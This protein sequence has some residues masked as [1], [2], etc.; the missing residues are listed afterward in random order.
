MMVTRGEEGRGRTN[1]IKEVKYMVSEE[2]KILSGKHTI[3]YT[4]VIL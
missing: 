4:D 3:K 1:W 2:D